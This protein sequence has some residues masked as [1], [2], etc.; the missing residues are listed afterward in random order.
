MGANGT[1][2]E[3]LNSEFPLLDNDVLQ[4][5]DGILENGVE[6]FK[7]SCDVYEALG[8]IFH[9]VST[10]KTEQDIRSI[11]QK[12]F[13][14]ILPNGGEE[15][16]EKKILD[17][18]VQLGRMGNEYDDS[19]KANQ[20][21]WLMTKTDTLKVNSKKLEKAE[22]KIQQKLEKREKDTKSVI[23]K[24]PVLQSASVSQVCFHCV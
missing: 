19:L 23:I 13:I 7:S 11:C 6:D 14:N 8:E 10:E 16:T 20:S 3:I 1:Y 12:I 18:P 15:F 2:K 9:D 4:Y 5:I 24:A 17:A 22:A 21:I